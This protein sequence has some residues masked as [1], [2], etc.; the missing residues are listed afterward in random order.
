MNNLFEEY[1]SQSISGSMVFSHDYDC[2][3]DYGYD[4]ND[5]YIDEDVDEPDAEWD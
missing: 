2:H 3:S 4:D 5:I 1:V